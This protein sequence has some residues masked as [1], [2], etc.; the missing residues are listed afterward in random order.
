MINRVFDNGW[1]GDFKVK[2]YEKSLV[3]EIVCN[4]QGLAI[5]NSTWYTNE[6]HARVSEQLSSGRYNRIVLVAMIDAAIP[7]PSWFVNTGLPVSSIGYYA[8]PGQLDF[9][10]L[11]FSDHCQC[12]PAVDINLPFMCLNR[13]PHPHRVELYDRLK[14]LDLLDQGLVSLGGIR[15][16]K[17][18]NIEVGSLA[19]NSDRS[20]YGI[21]ND[22]A[23]LGDPDNWRRCFLN[24]VTETWFDINQS[25]F[26]SEKIYKPIVGERPF[27]VYASDGGVRWL[28]DRG[29]K[30]FEKDFDD[31]TDLDLLEP[32]NLPEF[33]SI[34]CR[35]S[36]SYW[37]QKYIDL[38]PKVAYNKQ[39]FYTYV[40]EQKSKIKKGLQC[41]I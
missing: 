27:L 30:T 8:G 12:Q 13:K 18:K 20:H 25:G 17:E 2:S 5:I 40:Q 35:Q 4:H 41:Q 31:L 19:P 29:F 21:V 36:R 11:F 22:I 7:Q 9:W 26:V 15:S 1:G 16:I 24:I 6:Y 32:N 39:R 23:S 38:L 3:D 14:A 28:H 33:L 37:K 34:L 10:A